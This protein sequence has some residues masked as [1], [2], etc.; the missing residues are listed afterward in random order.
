MKCRVL[1]VCADSRV[2]KRII[3]RGNNHVWISDIL[4]LLFLLVLFFAYLNLPS[5]LLFDFV[6]TLLRLMLNRIKN[7]NSGMKC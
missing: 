1:C 3:E 5:N 2:H 7:W 4:L 6:V